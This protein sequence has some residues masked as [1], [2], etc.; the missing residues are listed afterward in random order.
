MLCFLALRQTLNT[1]DHTSPGLPWG[2]WRFSHDWIMHIVQVQQ[3]RPKS[4]GVRVISAVIHPS[5]TDFAWWLEPRSCCR[6]YFHLRRLVKIP[7]NPTCEWTLLWGPILIS[8]GPSCSPASGGPGWIIFCCFC[9]QQD[10][11][12]LSGSNPGFYKFHLCTFVNKDCRSLS[13]NL[14]GVASA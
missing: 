14:Q 10:E 8:S 6:C 2:W 12:R 4:L 13:G 11:V 5:N 9:K 7:V 1:A 3:F